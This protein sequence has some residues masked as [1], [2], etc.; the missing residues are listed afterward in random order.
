VP[1]RHRRPLRYPRIWGM[2]H[3]DP[4]GVSVLAHETSDEGRNTARAKKK[5]LQKKPEENRKATSVFWSRRRR[6]RQL[7]VGKSH[8]RGESATG[9]PH[10][11]GGPPRLPPPLPDGEMQ[12]PAEQTLVL[13]PVVPNRKALL[14][15]AITG[16]SPPIKLTSAVD[17]H[18]SVQGAL[19][20]YA[21]YGSAAE[22]RRAQVE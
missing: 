20:M 21:C 13:K 1:N 4:C 5:M 2:P 3:G 7:A 12:Y 9:I 18:G 17:K 19:L 16:R 10:P 11:L 14:E 22:A 15:T 8:H 6:T